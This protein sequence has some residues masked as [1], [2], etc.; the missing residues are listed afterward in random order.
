MRDG[1]KC[2]LFVCVMAF[3][4]VIG[5]VIRESTRQVKQKKAEAPKTHIEYQADYVANEIHYMRDKRTGVCFGYF[6][7][8]GY[9]T[10]SMTEVPC[11]KVQ[12]LL[13]DDQ[14]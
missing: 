12:N 9:D 2:I 7:L 11:D 8:S 3:I 13:P 1:H 10:F 4:G 5:S 6:L 14:K